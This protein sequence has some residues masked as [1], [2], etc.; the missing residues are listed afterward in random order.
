MEIGA[1]IVMDCTAD[2]RV[3]TIAGCKV[4][5]KDLKD[6]EIREGNKSQPYNI[7]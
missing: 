3:V 1:K 7:Y 5:E 4:D 2:A 6:I